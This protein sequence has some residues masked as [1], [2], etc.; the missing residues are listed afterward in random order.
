VPDRR[1]VLRAGCALVGAAATAGCSGIPV[2]GDGGT[3][4]DT[5]SYTDWLAHGNRSRTRFSVR[6]PASLHER[7]GLSVDSLDL[8]G[9]PSEEQELVVRSDAVTVVTG[10]FEVATVE[11]FLEDNPLG[12]SRGEDYRGFQMYETAEGTPVQAVGVRD[13][14]AV[15][16]SPTGIR[17]TIDSARG[18]ATRLVEASDRF[19]RL[20]RDLGD[21]E[22]I[23]GSGVVDRERAAPARHEIGIA[24]GR[25]VALQA[26]SAA[27]RGLVVFGAE[28]A[29]DEAAVTDYFG[30]EEG[31]SDVATTVDGR[32]ATATYSTPL[33]SVR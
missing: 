8:L 14:T 26:S 6:R 1:A 12:Y 20:I 17:V 10:S 33:E 2:G 27:V 7:S 30:N 21:G 4:P 13:G 22:K 25:R 15:S 31:A 29:V 18:D 5:S 11:A 32:I 24:R 23:R 28:D 9:I 16:A 3:A 19:A